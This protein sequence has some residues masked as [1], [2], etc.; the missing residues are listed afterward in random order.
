MG[1]SDAV[2]RAASPV[3]REGDLMSGDTYLLT[4]D[5]PEFSEIGSSHPH[6]PTKCPGRR[7]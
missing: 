6:L 2:A 4:N 1:G 7:A 5:R 3:S